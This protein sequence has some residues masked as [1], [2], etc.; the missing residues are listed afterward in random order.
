MIDGWVDM[1]DKQINIHREG[2]IDDRER[3]MMAR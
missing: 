2:Q 3:L 1:A